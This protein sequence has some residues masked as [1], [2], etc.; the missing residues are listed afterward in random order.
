[1]L[2]GAV[3]PK[4]KKSSLELQRFKKGGHYYEEVP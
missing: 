2:S 4:L 3:V 1:M